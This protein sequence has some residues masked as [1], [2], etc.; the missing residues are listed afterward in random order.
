[1]TLAKTV[2]LNLWEQ[3]E[4]QFK[5][6]DFTLLGVNDVQLENSMVVITWESLRHLR[7][8]DD[9]CLWVIQNTI[10]EGY[11]CDIEYRLENSPNDNV[12]LSIIGERND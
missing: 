12:Y 6:E 4:V 8:Y 2:R 9:F 5:K 7:F 1:M 11:K 3:Y 10:R